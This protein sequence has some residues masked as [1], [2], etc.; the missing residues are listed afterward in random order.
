MTKGADPPFV[1]VGHLN[2]PHGTEGEFFVWSL[3]DR[4][5]EVFRPD[6]ELR[7]SDSDGRLPDEFFPPIR[8]AETR[9]YKKGFLV[10]FHGVE[11]RNRAEFLRDR[12]LLL[13]FAEVEELEEGEIFYHQLL[14]MEVR[15]VEGRLLGTVR[16]V[17]TVDPADLLQVSDGQEEYLIPF[18]EAIVVEVDRDEGTVTVDPPPGLL[19][20]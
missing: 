9:P 15:T 14:G 3:T 12:Y 11:D 16:E 17:Y 7:I 2:K 10:R 18:T 13:P 20:L 19:D 1:V 8:I 6:R 4:P 5:H